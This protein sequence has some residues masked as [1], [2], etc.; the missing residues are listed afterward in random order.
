MCRRPALVRKV[1]R[2]TV[3]RMSY[4]PKYGGSLAWSFPTQF[5]RAEISGFS[6]ATV[7]IEQLANDGTRVP[8]SHG[9]GFMWRSGEDIWLITARHVLS[10]TNPFDG[11]HLRKEL[12]EPRE[13]RVHLTIGLNS[14]DRAR[15]AYVLPLRDS[16]DNALWAEDPHFADLKTDIAALKISVGRQDIWCINDGPDFGSYDGM[17]TH[18]G[19]QCFV[20]GYPTRSVSG[21]MLPIWRSGAIASDPAL[22]IDDKPIFLVDAATGPGFSGSPVW[23]IQIGP[24]AFHDDAVETKIRIDSDAVL[25]A[26]FVGVYA[27]RLDHPHVGA[28]TP[29]VFYANRIP[30]ILAANEGRAAAR[31][32]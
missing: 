20:V 26:S 16:K 18:V 5:P 30:I 11:S 22:P 12:Y 19:F 25:R 9:T 17:F 28:Q 1:L 32:V 31:P 13:I 15:Q 27:G 14:S 21:L 24:T 6:L 3:A 29:Y 8:L 23:R 7:L 2:R 10:G 4:T